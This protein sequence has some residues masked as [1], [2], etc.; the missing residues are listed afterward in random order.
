MFR[1]LLIIL[2]LSSYLYGQEPYI[3]LNL[4]I[5]GPGDDPGRGII[6]VEDGYILDVSHLCYGGISC[7]GLIKTDF[8]GVIEWEQVY[9]NYPTSLFSSINSILEDEEGHILVTGCQYSEISK[10]DIFLMKLDENGDSLWKK[11]YSLQPNLFL[12]DAGSRAVTT[13]DGG[14]LIAGLTELSDEPFNELQEVYYVKTD[15]DGEVE[16]EKKYT[17]EDYVFYDVI[18]ISKDIDGGYIISGAIEQDTIIGAYRAI[19]EQ[20]LIIK[21]D[22]FGEV[23][24]EKTYGYPLEYDNLF[25]WGTKAIPDGSGYVMTSA[26]PKDTVDYDWDNQELK[27]FYVA[28]LDTEGEIV[29]QHNFPSEKWKYIN[30]FLITKDG[31]YVIGVGHNRDHNLEVVGGWSTG[32]M[33]KIDLSTG[34]LLWERDYI[35]LEHLELPIFDLNSIVEADNGTLV[36]VGKIQ[37]TIPGSSSIFDM[38]WLLTLDLE[39]CPEAGTCEDADSVVY[40][41]LQEVTDDFYMNTQI[42]PF[43]IYPNPTQDYLIIEQTQ[44]HQNKPLHC[45]IYNGTGQLVH[46]QKLNISPTKIA[47]NNLKSGI[48]LCQLQDENGIHHSEKILIQR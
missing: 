25:V 14:Y 13:E 27:E 37:D 12:N 29:W 39:G 40:L 24:W 18:D 5:D 43:Q 45:K 32:W 19:F 26:V 23:V 16:W 10:E 30:D 31:N 9:S 15:E 33:F 22:S 42:S 38:A 48:Y 8:S 34:E 6:I 3:G 11:T 47:V 44:S 28:R 4:A 21:I 17:Y 1:T 20:G 2:F 46:E 36:A 35:S 7:V 41:N